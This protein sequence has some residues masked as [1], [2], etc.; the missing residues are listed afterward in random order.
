MTTHRDPGDETNPYADWPVRHVP[1]DG[2]PA[3]D[4]RIVGGNLEIRPWPLARAEAERLR[5]L[6]A[7]LAELQAENARLVE[8]IAALRRAARREAP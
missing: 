1:T 7:L 6:A 4:L 2:P 3:D 5:R 8:E